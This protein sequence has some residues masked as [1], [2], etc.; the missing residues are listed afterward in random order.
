MYMFC[1]SCDHA[2]FACKMIE[3]FVLDS[4]HFITELCLLELFQIY[5]KGQLE[6]I[7]QANAKWMDFTKIKF[8]QLLSGEFLESTTP[9]SYFCKD[10]QELA[11]QAYL[12]RHGTQE[13]LPDILPQEPYV[14]LCYYAIGS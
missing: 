6:K 3:T 1:L 12:T 10:S 5:I 4:E 14:M 2:Y 9:R 8:L 7:I 11:R 13:T